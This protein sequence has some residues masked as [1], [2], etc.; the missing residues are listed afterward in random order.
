MVVVD[1]VSRRVME[2]A[3]KSKKKGIVAMSTVV[4]DPPEEGEVEAAPKTSKESA[5]RNAGTMVKKATWS[6]SARRNA[7][8]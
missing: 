1:E 3:D 4:P 8:T 7:S 5:L 2:A 6:A